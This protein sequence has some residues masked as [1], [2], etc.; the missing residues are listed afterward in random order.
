[1]VVLYLVL[2]LL[3]TNAT[4]LL[5]LVL[6]LF[7]LAWLLLALASLPSQALVVERS[8]EYYTNDTAYTIRRKVARICWYHRHIYLLIF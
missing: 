8:T 4:V 6:R 1:M 3:V 2:P 5:V 7:G